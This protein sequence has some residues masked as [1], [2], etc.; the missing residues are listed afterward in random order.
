MTTINELTVT[1]V[2]EKIVAIVHAG[3]AGFPTDGFKLG[4]YYQVTIDPKCISPSGKYIRF[5]GN[6]GDE[7]VGWQRAEAITIIEIL[8]VWEE[9]DKPPLLQ[10][11]DQ[12]LVAMSVLSIKSETE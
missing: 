10:Y 9:N 1:D 3:P 5:G 7:I 2:K 11:G 4:E 12:G 6:Q 8:G